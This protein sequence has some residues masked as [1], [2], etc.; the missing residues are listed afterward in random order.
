MSSEPQA[1]GLAT[2]RRYWSA[3]AIWLGVTMA[4]LDGSIAN[5]ALPSMARDLEASAAGSIWIVNAYQIAVTVSLLPLAALGDILGYRRVYLA[6]LAV[7]TVASLGCA[8]A[9]SL[10]EL[11]AARVLQGLGAAG[12][13]SING[14]LLRFTFPQRL[15]GRGIG[16]NAVVVSLSAALGPTIA[17]AVLAIADWPV[18]FA[19]N[20]PIGLLA[21]AIGLRAL[22]V[23]PRANRRFDVASAALAAL[24]LGLVIFGAETAGREEW[25]A[26]FAM[27]AAGVVAGYVLMRRELRVA[28]PL[29]PLDLLRIPV[30]RLSVMTSILSFSAQM[31][32]FV[33]LPFFLQGPLGRSV[34]ETGLLMT[35]WPLAV[36]VA[37]P[38]A[39]RLADRYPAGLLG[40]FGLVTLAVGLALLA[41]LPSGAGTWQIV[42][43]MVLCGLGFGFFQSPNNR[44]MLSAAP[45]H[46]SGAAGGTLATARLVGQTAGATGMAILFHVSEAR[47][48]VIGLAIAS[49]LS[50]LA[51]GVSSLRRA[52]GLAQGA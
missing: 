16:L 9:S 21:I 49:G 30:F 36:A 46:R 8:L 14:A 1:D 31:L 27:I 37:A 43:P 40:A 12:I 23:T 3:A 50:V 38:I 10:P 18:L 33:S 51:A 32:A 22:P 5:V 13:M 44:T 26:G 48:T 7:F 25:A 20:L 15:L 45:R 6:G 34:V 17:S 42:L 52:G 41:I 39:G 4:V 28:E 47:A 11:V 35:P 29:V 19:V 2:P 24:T